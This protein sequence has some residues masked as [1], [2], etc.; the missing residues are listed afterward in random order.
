MD[1]PITLLLLALQAVLSYL[2]LQNMRLFELLCFR[3]RAVLEQQE[4]FRLI[5]SGFIHVGLVH[6]LVNGVSLYSFG[7]MIERNQGPATL[8]LIFL[9]SVIGG[10][11]LAL[12]LHRKEDYTAV[13]ASGGVC[14]VIFASLF[15]APGIEVMIFPIPVGIPSWLYA[16]GFLLYSY[17]GM[18]RPGT[19]IGH[20]AH[21]GG[22][23][24]GVGVTLALYPAQVLQQGRLLVG[25]V[26]LAVVLLGLISRQE[27]R[28]Y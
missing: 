13:G 11:L 10:N 28:R 8:A 4:W 25:V 5:S 14:G 23:L 17:F 15:L 18:N 12:W 7:P 26:L 6:F 24:V 16:I 22:A 27:G 2:A 1:S 21:F 3:P 19:R 9:L 20:D